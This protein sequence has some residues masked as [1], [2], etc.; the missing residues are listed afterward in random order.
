MYIKNSKIYAAIIGNI[1]I[2]NNKTIS[3][4]PDN[5][6]NKSVNLNI[7]SIILG[8][9]YHLNLKFFIE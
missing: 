7:G 9:V 1:I 5:I 3:V 6:Q 4:M 2:N 8:K